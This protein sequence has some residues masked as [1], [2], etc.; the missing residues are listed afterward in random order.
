MTLFYATLL[1]TSSLFARLLPS[2][3]KSIMLM[4]SMLMI[5]P[6]LYDWD[7]GGVY[8]TADGMA[9][10]L[11][12]LTAYLM[13]LAII[14]NWNNINSMLFFEL[15]LALGGMLL[16]NFLC[17]DMLSFYVYFEASLVPL[18][19]MIG[20][21]GANNRE[22]A[23]DYI[24]I[25]TLLSSLFMLIGMATYELLLGTTDYQA[26]SL[27]V[28]SIDLQ[29]MLFMTMAIGVMVKTP[30]VPVHTWLPVVHSESPLA[31]SMLL[32]GV[33]LKLAMYAMMRLMLPTL[34]DASMLYTPI[35][36]M[37]CV[38]TMIYT[39]LMT[40][41]Q[42]DL[43]VMVAYSSVSHMAV[44]MLGMLSNNMMGMTGSLLLCMAHGFVSPALF[45]MVGGMLYDRYHHRL[46]YYYQGLMKTMPLLSM[47]LMMLSF[48]N[49]GTP[50]SLNFM[51]ELLSLTGSV[52]RSPMLGAMS[53]MSVLLSASY[54]MKVTNRLTGGMPT[55]YTKL[56]A[57]C[58]Y[59]ELMM[60]FALMMPTMYYGM[61][62]NGMMN[63]LWQVPR[64]MYMFM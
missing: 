60:L 45:M 47:M 39:S 62:P 12:L 16:I 38:M 6:T 5:M 63:M 28:L 8:Y 31:G 59:R 34:S 50:L 9:D 41:R 33:M 46:M 49:V 25:Y 30:L 23:S 29:C 14:A 7:E 32:A 21:Y 55:P 13:P 56:T 61:Y 24:L 22:K 44:C 26:V 53:T 20:L 4:A 42:T 36:Y 37:M 18:F 3:N 57:D 2:I 19:I 11:I 52:G 40:L 1:S 17:Q 54:M 48:S 51:G 15:V 64:L 10:M 27:V 43:K 58:T 35:A